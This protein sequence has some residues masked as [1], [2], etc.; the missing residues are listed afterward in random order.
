ML[1]TDFTIQFVGGSFWLSFCSSV[2]LSVNQSVYEWVSAKAMLSSA[3]LWKSA[4]SSHVCACQSICLLFCLSVS[5]ACQSCL[6]VSPSVSLFLCVCINQSICFIC[7]SVSSLFVSSR[8]L[9]SLSI[10]PTVRLF[11]CWWN[12]SL[13]YRAAQLLTVF[14]FMY[15]CLSITH[16]NI[17]SL[18]SLQEMFQ[19]RNHKDALTSTAISLTLQK[20]ATCGDNCVKIHDLSELKEMYAIITV[21]DD[22]GQLDRMEWTDDGQLLAVGT[23]TGCVHTYLTKLPVLGDASGTRLAYLTSLL[24]VTVSNNVDQVGSNVY[25]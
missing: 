15:A 16:S 2:S 23:R 11:G 10:S 18:F 17:L 19:A 6:S 13:A 25:I 1:S 14:Y 7:P 4:L 9:L 24:E 21:E 8:I 3:C 20:A 22:Q 12:S 5:F